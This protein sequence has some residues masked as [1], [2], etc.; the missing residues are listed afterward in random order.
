MS[1][2]SETLAAQLWPQGSGPDCP[3]AYALL[4]GARDPHIAHM[5]RTS[6]LPFECLYAGMLTS[7]LAA[8]APYLVQLTPESRF[9]KD[10]V[11]RAWGNAWGIF[12]V[13]RP[14][15]TLHA[16]RK[17]FRTILRVKDEQGQILVFRFYDPRVLRVYLPTCTATELT[18]VFGL[19]DTIWVE[20]EGAEC[21]LK[22]EAPGRRGSC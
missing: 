8:A 11:P 15:V 20:A 21:A 19:V 5:V 2:T 17:H 14:D 13:A 10:L 3:Q 18:Q 7:A 16:M 4:D 9:Y 12:V 6:G 22:F 1:V